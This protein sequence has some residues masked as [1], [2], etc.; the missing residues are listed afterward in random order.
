MK[1]ACGNADQA[2]QL[3]LESNANDENGWAWNQIKVTR[4]KTVSYFTRIG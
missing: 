3:M 2:T 1:M 4:G